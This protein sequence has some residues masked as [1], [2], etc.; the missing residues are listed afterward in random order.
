MSNK[1]SMWDLK[2]KEEYKFEYL[3]KYF[4][5]KISEKYN[6]GLSQDKYSGFELSLFKKGNI[7]ISQVKVKFN[8]YKYSIQNDK[9][10][11]ISNMLIMFE[12]NEQTGFIIEKTAGGALAFL[13]KLCGID[14]GDKEVITAHNYGEAFFDDTLFYWIISNIYTGDS[15]KSIELKDGSK[16]INIK[17]LDGI[18][19]KTPG[20]F[21]K[22]SV[23]GSD[24]VNMLTTLS[25]LLESESLTDVN[26]KFLYANHE[27][28]KIDIHINNILKKFLSID[29]YEDSYRG[30]FRN[31]KFAKSAIIKDGDNLPLRALLLLMIHLEFLPNIKALFNLETLGIDDIK[32]DLTDKIV[33]DVTERMKNLKK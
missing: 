33:E 16:Q 32:K 27:S 22:V 3:E 31:N 13:R 10:E 15:N 29:V 18:K 24:V 20:V 23:E 25:I 7:L 2:N 4:S 28:I 1:T 9:G 5:E 30:D 21:N 12:K 6:F 14:A 11:T 26:L 17:S 8:I 19:G